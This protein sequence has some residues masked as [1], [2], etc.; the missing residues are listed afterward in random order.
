[1]V[2]VSAIA[3]AAPV[4]TALSRVECRGRAGVR[5]GVDR[6][7]AS[8]PGSPAGDDHPGRGAR[9]CRT[10]RHGVGRP[11]AVHGRPVVERAA[12]RS[13]STVAGSPRL[14]PVPAVR[15]GG[16]R[17]G[18]RRARR[19]S[20]PGSRRGRS[21]ACSTSRGSVCRR[22]NG[23]V[24]DARPLRQR[25]RQPHVVPPSSNRASRAARCASVHSRGGPSAVAA[26]PSR[27]RSGVRVCV[28]ALG[29]Q[30]HQHVGMSIAH[31]AD[32]VA[33]AAQGR[34]VRQRGVVLD[35]GQLRAT[36]RADRARVDRAV[37]MAAGPL[38]DRADVQAGRAA[39]AAQR[40]AA[41]LVGEDAVRPLSSRTRWNSCGPS[42]GVTPVHIEVYGFIRSPVERA[43][44]QLQEHLQVAPGRHELLDAHDGDQRLGQR[45]AHPAVAL[46]LD[47]AERAG[48]GDG[49]VGAGDR[50][51]RARNFS[52][53]CRAS[54]SARSARARRSDPGRST[55]GIASRKM[56]RIS[57]RL[58]WIAGT[59]MWLRWSCAE[60][61]DELGEIGLVAHR[62]RPPRVLR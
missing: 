47:D 53:R 35:A 33:G 14:T 48:L 44:Q 36:A 24:A 20:G 31:R 16:R 58:R 30:V 21:I 2:P 8:R 15:F 50:D 57:L 59:R 55:P 26:A 7:A 4:S 9:S 45:Q 28:G 12:R 38:V 41:D 13:R 37:G 27:R 49:E 51:R 46:G 43:R 19:G 3:T 1:M 11:R 62:C 25:R 39:D 40:L 29:A 22:R 34:G 52:R 5:H 6:R 54:A 10:P 61:H 42:P 17:A 60:L 18:G 23:Q 32:V 56:S